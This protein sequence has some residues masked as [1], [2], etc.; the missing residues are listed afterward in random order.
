MDADKVY[1]RLA[2][3]LRAAEEE[4]VADLDALVRIRSVTGD[5]AAAQA[6]MADKYRRLGLQVIEVEAGAAVKD[7]PQF[8]PSPWPAAGRPNLVATVPDAG[9]R[10]RSLILNGHID[11]VPAAEQ[12]GWTRDPWQ[13]GREQD[14]FYGRGAADMK[15]GL[16]AN[17]HLVAALFDLGLRPD[18]P[19][20]LHSVIEE[21]AGGGQGTLALLAEGHVAAAM[22]IP[23]PLDQHVVVGHPGV[24][25]FRVTVQG[26]TA[27]AGQSH[28]GVNAIGKMAAIYQAL[29]ELDADRARRYDDPFFSAWTG[30]AVNL[31]IGTLTA[32]DW[33]STVAGQAVMQCRISFIPPETAAEMQAEVEQTIRRVAAAD[34]WLQEHPPRIEWFGWRAQPWRQDPDHPLVNLTA[35][36]AARVL[37][38]RVEPV[39]TT[40]GLDTRFAPAFGMAAVS[41]GPRGERIHGPDECVYISSVIE[42]MQVYAG[43]LLQWC[44]IRA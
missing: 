4:L 31:N 22:L 30:R 32:G 11:V 33:V 17:Y 10:G 40:A 42:T 15:A 41:F 44:G 26:R 14:R 12:A 20:Y 35:Q 25:Y 21:E 27:H 5:E 29:V 7:H 1:R 37:Q 23:E 34:P 13:G 2:D 28:Y 39:A 43:V 38:R 24:F 8:T 36:Q 19:L 16:L 6:F 18:A 3:R 9:S